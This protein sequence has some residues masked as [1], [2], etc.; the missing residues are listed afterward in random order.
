MVNNIGELKHGRKNDELHIE[1]EETCLWRRCSIQFLSGAGI[2]GKGD[3]QGIL[4]LEWM[5]TK[6][7]GLRN[8]SCQ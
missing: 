3:S 5:E 4:G 8:G 2:G 1:F 7:H 6:W